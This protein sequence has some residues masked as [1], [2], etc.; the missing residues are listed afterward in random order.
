MSVILQVK[1]NGGAPQSGD[2]ITG[3]EILAVTADRIQLTA[4][5]KVGWSGSPPARW[6]MYDYP[7]G[8]ALP[9]GW[10][11]EAATGIYYYS[12]N[13]DP[14]IVTVGASWGKFVFNLSATEGTTRTTDYNTGVIV[15]GPG[16]LKGMGRGEGARFGGAHLRW[17]KNLMQ[18]AVVLSAAAPD[19]LAPNFVATSV[20]PSA[21]G[22]YTGSSLSYTSSIDPLITDLR[23]AYTYDLG[24]AAAVATRGKMPI[25]V[26]VHGYNGN[27]SLISDALK[28]RAASMGFFVLAPEMRGRGAVATM[29]G[30]PTDVDF[31]AGAGTITRNT[32]SWIT[33][34]FKIGHRLTIASTVSNNGRPSSLVTAV[35]ATVLTV[36]GLVTELNV[37]APAITGAPGKEDDS[38]RELQD[39]L[40]MV[41]AA[42]AANPTLI[43]GRRVEIGYSGGGAN[44]IAMHAKIIDPQVLVRV[45]L[46]GWGDYGE[47]PATGP[48]HSYWATN[49]SRP[50]MEKRVG[51]RSADFGPYR[52]RNNLR[53]IAQGAE[54]SP[55]PLIF[56]WDTGDVP[57]GPSLSVDVRQA[58]LSGGISKAKWYAQ[59][60]TVGSAIRWQHGYVEDFPAL[61]NAEYPAYRYREVAAAAATA[62]KRFG[63]LTVGGW[64]KH[65][66]FEIWTAPTG[67]EDPKR[68]TPV[69][70]DGGSGGGQRYLVDVDYNS[71]TQQY[72]VTP[73]AD[74]GACAVQIVT[75]T[76][77]VLVQDVGA[78]TPVHF[79]VANAK[80]TLRGYLLSLHA[81]SVYDARRT[82]LEGVGNPCE[83]NDPV[84]LWDT[85]SNYGEQQ[86]DTVTTYVPTYDAADANGYPNLTFVAAQQDQMV[87][88]A[89]DN[90]L[91]S[92]D[93]TIVCVFARD[94][95][96][97]AP[98][99]WY[100]SAN[101]RQRI[102]LYV[103]A[104]GCRHQYV[105]Q[106]LDVDVTDTFTVGTGRHVAILERVGSALYITIDG[107]TRVTGAT[108]SGTLNADK[109][110]VGCINQ[111][112]AQ[113]FLFDGRVYAVGRLNRGMTATERAAVYARAQADWGVT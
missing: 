14:P 104:N 27:A 35:T 60:S 45:A 68:L 89:T 24:R 34:G 96:A 69:N 109:M 67:T 111:L 28:F 6:E 103:D 56:L 57:L 42:V 19:D 87:G 21:S 46:F 40:D 38:Q 52:A 101:G 81:K 75:P 30:A 76:Q 74:S 80:N 33:D 105:T 100:D 49:D 36:G 31:D 110:S 12:G 112:G 62:T 48:A 83:D 70:G 98:C 17:V 85:V 77:N 84:E 94:A 47:S 102:D 72:V 39:I 11:S 93:Y 3:T 106:T 7:P 113:L 9:A 66:D 65:E 22:A 51:V 95:N 18:D 63:K 59:E 64:A 97:G 88:S 92:T 54:A 91:E 25:C 53:T 55:T 86:L 79:D 44:V 78:T 15:L 107:R 82:P 37:N 41:T 13:E 73:R 8:F 16:G 20:D 10:T 29:A 61:I 71:I 43:D 26:F 90:L 1:I 2:P 32:G 99:G 23:A 50:E 58:L 4:A 5:S 108:V